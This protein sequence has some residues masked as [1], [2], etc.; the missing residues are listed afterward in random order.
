MEAGVKSVL[1]R[2]SGR[3]QHVGFRMWAVAR[4]RNSG[5]TGW[6]RNCADGSVE[7]FV[8][9]LPENVENFCAVLKRGPPY[10]EVG[11]I[12]VEDAQPQ[13]LFSFSVRG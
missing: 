8:Q 11:R 5:V 13:R 2:I 12:S 6:I 7:A 1:V 9:G 10:A 4:A 3:V